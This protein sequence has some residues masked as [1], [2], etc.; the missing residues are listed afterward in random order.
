[1]I[2]FSDI[3]DITIEENRLRTDSWKKEH[4]FDIDL[5]AH[6]NSVSSEHSPNKTDLY[7]GLVIVEE[8]ENLVENNVKTDAVIE[9]YSEITDKDFVIDPT[10]EGSS[11]TPEI[12]TKRTG[13]NND[14]RNVEGNMDVELNT[15]DNYVETDA[16]IENDLIIVE[17][18]ATIDF[19]LKENGIETYAA[20]EKDSGITDVTLKKGI[21]E[22][23]EANCIRT[24][25]TLEGNG[26][27]THITKQDNCKRTNINVDQ[28]NI[29]TVIT[30]SS[31]KFIL[32]PKELRV[33]LERI[34]L[35]NIKGK[36]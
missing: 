22:Q 28:S 36:I 21:Q 15:A 30:Q 19:N 10:I 9:K 35:T 1:M 23:E 11:V 5:T 14:L 29:R 4:N 7:N 34:T 26:L 17:Q 8:N 32:C 24:G 33:V 20:I 18:N 16:F 2:F 31:N 6:I 12:S 25:L 27:R 13:L 3:E